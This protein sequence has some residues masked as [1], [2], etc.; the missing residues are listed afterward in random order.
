M[1]VALVRPET[2]PQVSFRKLSSLSDVRPYHKLHLT[3]KA[4]TVQTIVQ[5]DKPAV[6]GETVSF[7]ASGSA[8]VGTSYWNVSKSPVVFSAGQTE[9]V[10]EHQII[11]RG[12]YF[13]SV[14]LDLTL[15]GSTGLR[16]D[17]WAH[18][19]RYTIRPSVDPPV[20]RF[21]SGS[22]SV[23]PGGSFNLQVSLSA[24][25][26][27]DVTLLYE[28]G[29]TVD[30]AN[31]TIPASGSLTI[32]AGQVSGT[33][34][35]SFTLGASAGETLRVS[36][37][38]ESGETDPR[39][40]LR[41]W[42]DPLAWMEH[43]R[44]E[45]AASFSDPRNF[46]GIENVEIRESPVIPGS[47]SNWGPGGTVVSGPPGVHAANFVDQEDPSPLINPFTGLAHKI[48][49]FSPAIV[50]GTPYLRESFA[51][52][53][54]GGPVK[55]GNPPIAQGFYSKTRAGAN[56]GE[57]TGFSAGRIFIDQMKNARPWG[58]VPAGDF[59]FGDTND[60]PATDA[61][62]W[63]LAERLTDHFTLINWDGGPNSMPAGDYLV[64]WEGQGEVIFGQNVDTGF[65]VTAKTATVGNSC[66][67]TVDPTA[68]AGIYCR[69]RGSSAVDPVRN[70]SILRPGYDLSTHEVFSPE[71]LAYMRNF[72][73]VRFMD[74]MGTNFS[75]IATS[76]DFTAVDFYSY[77]G[78]SGVPLEIIMRACAEAQVNAWLCV[79]HQLNDAGVTYFAQTIRQ[80]CPPMCRVF[81]EY[82]NE[83]WN[84]QFGD[85]PY[86]PGAVRGQYDWCLTRADAL[87]ITGDD[88]TK[89]AKYHARRSKEV[90]DL[91]DAVWQVAGESVRRYRVLS[92][93]IATTYNSNTGLAET[94]VQAACD[95]VAVAPYVGR[96]IANDPS[97]ETDS[98]SVTQGLLD[99]ALVTMF[100]AG[101]FVDLH[102]QALVGLLNSDGNALRLAFYECGQDL[103]PVMNSLGGSW[104]DEQV[105]VDKA[106]RMNRAAAM[107]AWYS[108]FSAECEAL[109]DA[110][111]LAA[112]F[113]YESVSKYSSDPLTYVGQFGLAEYTGQSDSEKL[114]AVLAL[115]TI[116]ADHWNPAPF[117]NLAEWNRISYYVDIPQGKD[118]WRAKDVKYA[119]LSLRNRSKS[120]NH[121]VTFKLDFPS[122]VGQTDKA[123][124]PVSVTA[125]SIGNIGVWVI[126]NESGVTPMEYGVIEDE[127]GVRLW[128]IHHADFTTLYSG[129]TYANIG[130]V[131]D[132]GNSEANDDWPDRPYVDSGNP[133]LRPGWTDADVITAA[134]GI[135]NIVGQGLIIYG[136]YHERSSI[137]LSG[138]P[139][140]Y[141]RRARHWWEPAGRAVL[142]DANSNSHTL[143]V[144]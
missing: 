108:A 109:L 28:L 67:I 49:A 96:S 46:D 115:A 2:I 63:P 11:D 139:G 142:L 34:S 60:N 42:P 110:G 4:G 114:T 82:T 55:L 122:T 25:S 43:H 144:S 35:G 91:C 81:L 125:T 53:Y 117:G 70:I 23:A 68:G 45:N 74:W 77:A 119:Q 61:Q 94:G 111:T 48:Y 17:N 138:V 10:I 141:R 31:V 30:L 24:S 134:G 19:V 106:L 89:R 9:A 129:G 66:T 39:L 64:T 84:A 98:D 131:N 38:H 133:I 27:E 1:G 16:I 57:V 143:T 52:S 72:D 95:I 100:E 93:F 121:T 97:F 59:G 107:G 123:G 22:S 113:H 32:P 102:L 26:A 99:A 5:L 36:L 29:G 15:V 20:L 128:M 127:F 90:W 80:H 112:Y 73:A 58:S 51:D 75:P 88:N 101:G 69:I 103:T 50:N 18:R 65:A 79:P 124:S 140:P 105:V 14:D 83:Y 92:G 7:A 130:D 6:G 104:V 8:V 41:M 86:V 37:S 132:D 126:E 13:D 33:I 44:E 137:P 85:F 47:P 3:D 21:L 116:Q 76:A 12:E 136:V 118:S 56:V 135:E 78:S 71:F 87:G 40:A 54:C 120:L 62:G